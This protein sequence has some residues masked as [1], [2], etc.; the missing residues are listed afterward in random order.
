MIGVLI[1]TDDALRPKNNASTS[2][3][4]EILFSYTWTKPVSLSGRAMG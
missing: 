4:H 1:P 3:G 2:F